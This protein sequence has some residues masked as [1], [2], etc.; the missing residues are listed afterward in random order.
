MMSARRRR[1]SESG[2]TQGQPRVRGFAAAG[3]RYSV[4]FDARTVYDFLI[5]LSLMRQDQSDLPPADQRWLR[6]ARAA[7][8]ADILAGMFVGG[9]EREG[10]AAEMATVVVDRPELRDAA[11]LVAAVE[12]MPAIDI[13]H[14]LLQSPAGKAQA[15]GRELELALAGDP[16]ALR[17]VEERLATVALESELG[18]VRAMLRDPVAAAE[19]LH[20]ALRA[21]L[22]AFQQVEERV[23]TVLERDVAARRADTDLPAPELVERTTAGIRLLPDGTISRVILAPTYFSRPYNWAVV[24][25]GWRLFCYPVAESALESRGAWEPPAA[26]VQLYRALGDPQRLRVLHMLAE[27]DMY[28]T[29]IAQQLEVSKPTA[30][31]HLAQLRAAGLVTLIEEGAL[32]YY[33]LRRDRILAAGPEIGRYIS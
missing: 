13:V 24:G 19:R 20:L 33:S 9:D 21:W 7:L 29:E 18:H 8:P 6:D 26:T 4:S 28:L 15:A 1:N 22:P 31:H 2:T 3:G 11:A 17:D 23:R 30:S 12:A 25:D 32:T 10:L 5:S 16:E 14:A 27:R